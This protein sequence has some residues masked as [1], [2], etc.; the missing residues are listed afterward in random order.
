[1]ITGCHDEAQN[2]RKYFFHI[3]LFSQGEASRRRSD[4]ATLPVSADGNWQAEMSKLAISRKK[5][6]P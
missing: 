3:R 1:L 5:S 2:Y 6:E 4:L